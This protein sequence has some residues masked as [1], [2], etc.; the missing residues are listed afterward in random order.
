MREE[1]R[2]NQIQCTIM[3]QSVHMAFK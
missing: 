1:K 2:L 3:Q